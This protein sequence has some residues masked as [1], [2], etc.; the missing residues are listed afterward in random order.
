VAAVER[1]D[2]VEYFSYF[3]SIAR[4]ELVGRYRML[5]PVRWDVR[6]LCIM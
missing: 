6:P 5:L 4:P 1:E 3:L 2:L